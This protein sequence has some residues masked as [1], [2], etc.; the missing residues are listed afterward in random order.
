ME[1]IKRTTL[2]W[3]DNT[4]HI[5]PTAIV[6]HWWGV[7]VWFGGMKYAIWRLKRRGLSVQFM[8]LANG[9]IHQLVEDP[10]VLCHHARC[11]NESSI[12]IELQGLGKK[13]LN[14]QQ[15]QFKALIEL[16]SNL[17]KLYE[18]PTQ[19]SIVQ[20]PNTRFYGIASHKWIDKYCRPRLIKKRDVH[21]EYVN[22][23]MDA[24]ITK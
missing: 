11:A 19:F 22:R 15:R 2:P 14:K 6:L 5:L 3:A 9:E 7:P 8:I 24:L 18:I 13:D 10:T 1:D 20:Q 12:G 23:V 17:V 21:D 4:Q 16:V